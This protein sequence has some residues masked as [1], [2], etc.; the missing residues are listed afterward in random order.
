MRIDFN[1]MGSWRKGPQFDERDSELVKDAAE[2]LADLTTA[3]LRIVG[4][5]GEVVA[6]RDA[7]CGWRAANAKVVR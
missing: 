2:K 6:S 3:D 4:E 7:G 1:Q 5:S